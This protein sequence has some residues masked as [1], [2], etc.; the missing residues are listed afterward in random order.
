VRGTV[1]RLHLTFL[2]FLLWIGGVFYVRGGAGAAIDGVLFI[3]LLFGCVV[4]LEFGH[5]FAARRYGVQTPEVVL[6]PIG[7]VARME[8]IPEVPRQ[9]I[10]VALAG[11]A[12]NIV[13][14]LV[15]LVALGGQMPVPAAPTLGEE[16]L[17]LAGRLLYANLF[18]AFFNLVPAFPMGG[19]RVLRAALAGYVG[20]ARGTRI[21]AG[22]G[23]A[24][25]FAFGLVGL[26]AGNPILLFVA[27]FIYLAAASESHAAQM[28]QVAQGVMTADAMITHFERLRADARV[29]DAVECLLRTTQHEFPVCDG[30]DRLC[31]VLTRNAMIRALKEQGPQAPVVEVMDADIPE[32][33]D[34]SN[35]EEAARLLQEKNRPAVGVVD[36]QGRLVGL[37]TRETIGELMMV[38]GA[39]GGGRGDS[40]SP[41]SRPRSPA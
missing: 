2:L 26:A 39:R 30:D 15:L 3:A 6:L 10:A 40:A 7:G 28:R 34:R 24:L 32:V 11:P 8:R 5:I 27:L 38:E 35:L 37:I 41:W 19:G 12:V 13:L 25:A 16:G 29:D 9:E 36:R 4:L 17:G 22:I 18:L 14:A 33:R 1:I 20:Y 23:Q 31:G 21:A